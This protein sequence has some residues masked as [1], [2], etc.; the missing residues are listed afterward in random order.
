[1]TKLTLTSTAR[2]RL[3]NGVLALI[4]A[5]PAPP[6][7][8]GPAPEGTITVANERQ[9]RWIYQRVGISKS[10]AVSGTCTAPAGTSVEARIVDET[11]G[12]AIGDWAVV[13]TV[14]ANG[15]YAGTFVVPQ[16]QWYRRQ[17]RIAN[18][19]TAIATETNSF[20]VGIGILKYGQ[21]NMYN[22]LA[23]FKLAPL[24]DPNAYEC[25]VDGVLRRIGNISTKLANGTDKRAP[26][27]AR[28]GTG[29]YDQDYVSSGSN[30]DAHVYFAN[31]ITET[32]GLP[33]FVF[34]KAVIGQSIENLTTAS[35]WTN[36]AAT[37]ASLGGDFEMVVFYQGE[38]NIGD[39]GYKAK[40]T[41][42]HNKIMAL[43]G[44][45]ATTMKF[46]VVSLGPISTVS[47]WAASSTSLWGAMRAAQIDWAHTTPGA[48]YI[49]GRHDLYTGTDGLHLNGESFHIAG[50]RDAKSVLSQLGFGTTAAGPRMV[51]ASRTDSTVT[52][53]I[54]HTGGTALQDG[55][56]GTGADLR[57]F[58]F[59]D[60]AG[61]LVAISSTQITSATTVQ[62]NLASTPTG[63]CTLSYAMANAP[64]RSNE[65]DATLAVTPAYVLMD[66]ATYFV[67]A[68]DP[69]RG[70]PLQPCAAIAVS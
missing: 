14:Q 65:D 50:R 10:V 17:V 63:A 25:A 47:S 58:Q 59:R 67:T 53:T 69:S 66:N 28:F 39:A 24:G 2:L 70:C 16:G 55:A 57:G 31:L 27:S 32:T 30:G 49:G 60:G 26:N 62:L 13:G 38:N 19:S 52:V 44:R 33:V 1:M 68:N 43:V 34:N 9:L 51:S 21:S 11:T 12:I 41:T 64:L 46:G 23:T 18:S 29:G 6:A 54:A 7:D 35:P 40:L 37:T 36:M 42:L 4:A 56:G 61:A 45:D 22:E 8:P 15:T 48:F 3:R 5:I 20:G